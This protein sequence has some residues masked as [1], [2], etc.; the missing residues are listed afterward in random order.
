MVVS[1]GAL[2]PH[3][4]ALPGAVAAA[5]EGWLYLAGRLGLVALV[6]L[7]LDFYKAQLMSSGLSIVCGTAAKVY[8][9]RVLECMPHELLVEGFVRDSLWSSQ[10]G[11]AD[12]P[13]GS[14]FNL[15][16][17]SEHA[18]TWFDLAPGGQADGEEMEAANMFKMGPN[19]QRLRVSLGGMNP[20]QHQQAVLEVLQ[21]LEEEEEE[22]G[23]M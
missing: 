16:M 23:A 1:G 20:A 3:S 2:A 15:V 17:S 21:Q 10:L 9:R 11:Q 5:L 19:K 22:V 4:A 18:A 12:V 8:S 14:K 6:R 13:A 7:L